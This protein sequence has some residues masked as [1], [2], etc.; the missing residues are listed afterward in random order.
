MATL[1]CYKSVLTNVKYVWICVNL[2]LVLGIT[3][4][5]GTVNINICEILMNMVFD[6]DDKWKGFVLD[7]ISKSAL[8]KSLWKCEKFLNA[9]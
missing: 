7:C 3:T 1:D 5:H 9:K 2:I 8:I 6:W 4:F